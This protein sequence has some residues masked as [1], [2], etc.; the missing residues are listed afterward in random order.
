MQLYLIISL[1]LADVIGTVVAVG[2][3]VDVNSHGG[4]K[5]RRTVVIE[6]TEYVNQLNFVL[7]KYKIVYNYI[8]VFSTNYVDL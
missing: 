1:N 8:H 3:I 7:L 4:R 2:N 6:D 5:V